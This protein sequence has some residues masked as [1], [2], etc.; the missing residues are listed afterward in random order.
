MYSHELHFYNCV[1]AWV[2]NDDSCITPDKKSGF[3]IS[4]E[5]CKSRMQF[6]DQRTSLSE[7][8]QNALKSYSCGSKNDKKVCCAKGNFNLGNLILL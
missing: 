5:L 8:E 2:T 1:S 4:E 6:L 3:C 7:E